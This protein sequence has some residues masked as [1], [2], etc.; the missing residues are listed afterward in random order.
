MDGRHFVDFLGVNWKAAS[1]QWSIMEDHQKLPTTTKGLIDRTRK[2]C[3]MQAHAMRD[4]ES[5]NEERCKQGHVRYRI[6]FY[7]FALSTT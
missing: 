4:W 5:R 3:M 6:D 1:K 7:K 2:H